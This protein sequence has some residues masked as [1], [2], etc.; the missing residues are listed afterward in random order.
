MSS[1]RN[2]QRRSCLGFLGFAGFIGFSYFQD[3]NNDICIYIVTKDM[4]LSRHQITSQGLAIL[5]IMA[6]A[7]ATA[8][9]AK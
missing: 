1:K 8:G 9:L 6:E 3:H 5:P 2:R 7:A 4:S